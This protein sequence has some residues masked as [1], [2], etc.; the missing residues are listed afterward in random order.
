MSAADLSQREQRCSSPA[1]PQD[2]VLV[3]QQTAEHVRILV[4]ARPD[5]RPGRLRVLV[6]ARRKLPRRDDDDKDAVERVDRLARARRGRGA[7]ARVREQVRE[8]VERAAVVHRARELRLE[9]GDVR[10]PAVIGR[11][12]DGGLALL[13]HGRG[14]ERAGRHGRCRRG[15]GWLCEKWAA[16]ARRA[17]ASFRP[18]SLPP[19]PPPAHDATDGGPVIKGLAP[20]A[21]LQARKQGLLQGRVRPP[22]CPARR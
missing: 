16:P 14:R 11:P 20:R 1:Y 2:L 22:P 7:R 9:R 18:S 17:S 6:A 5:P 4:K 21:H 13:V 12:G 3:L 8:R 10:R 19:L 15:A